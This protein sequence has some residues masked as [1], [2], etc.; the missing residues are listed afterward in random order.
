MENVYQ[1]MNAA[2]RQRRETTAV[3]E[4]VPH[5]DSTEDENGEMDES[6]DPLEE[7]IIN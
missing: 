1:T 3:H 4:D 2:K 7:I 5:G 6:K